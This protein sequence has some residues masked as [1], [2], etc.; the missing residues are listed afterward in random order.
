MLTFTESG[1]NPEILKA[2][3]ELN[4]ITPTP[5]QQ[6]TIPTLLDSASDLIG[7]AQTGTGKTAAFGLPLVH[8]ADT[9]NKNVQALILC[10]TRELCIQITKDLESYSKYVPGFK[11]VA[12]YGGTSIRE[13]MRDLDRGCQLV[14]GTP[15]RTIDL[16]ER[17][18]LK[19]NNIRWLILDEADEMLNM[20]FKEDLDTILESVP[21]ERQTLLFSATMPKEISQISKKYM[22]NPTEISAGKKNAGAE[23]VSHEYYVVSARDRYSAL[24]RIVDLHPSIYALVFCRTRQETKDVSAKLIADGYNADSLHGDLSQAQRD[25]AMDRFRSKQLQIL[26]AT[27]VAARGLDVS[28]MTHVINYNLPDE[29]EV[30]IHRSGRTGR[31]GSLGIAVSIIHTRETGKIRN[32]EKISGKKFERKMVPGGKEICEKQLFSLIDKMEQVEINESQIDQFLPVIYKKLEWLSREELI[33]HFVSL[34]F[35]RFLAYYKNAPD[36]NVDLS[37]SSRGGGSEKGGEWGRRDSW[38]RGDRNSKR[39]RGGERSSN[40]D[41]GGERSSNRDRSGERSSSRDRVEERSSGRDRGGEKARGHRG[42]SGSFSRFYIN[43][44]SKHD[45]NPTKLIGLLNDNLKDRDVSVGKI[46]IMRNFSFF[47]VD[48]N[49][50]KKVI[51]SLKDSKYNNEKLIVDLSQPE[52][53]KTD[54][55]GPQDGRPKNKT[56]RKRTR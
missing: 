10:P 37:R 43:M 54:F 22:K 28:E 53:P 42:S 31:A 51:N 6:K 35:N 24:K 36:L 25:Y 19:V 7:L 47:E 14:V 2:V 5:I 41:R 45:L 15:G 29:L 20:G 30:Y 1:L 38:D 21:S 32:L 3:K 16:I 26:V 9:K 46:D 8:L 40:R 4:F 11:S 27:D 17:K 52:K 49:Y 12:V 13:Q 39:D 18:A 55:R 23:N 44:G 50:E 34:E 56:K 33:K 48:S